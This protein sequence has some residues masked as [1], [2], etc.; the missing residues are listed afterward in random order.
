MQVPGLAPASPVALVAPVQRRPVRQFSPAQQ[1][2]PLLA[3]HEALHMP[4]P[5][6]GSSHARPALQVL[7]GQQS[8][9]AP[10]HAWHIGV[11]PAISTQRA[12]I[13]HSSSS[14]PLQQGW[15]G[16]PHAPQVPGPGVS[17]Q[18][19][20]A[21]QVAFEQQGWPMPPHGL[22]V[23]AAA[24]AGSMQRVPMSQAMSPL[25]QG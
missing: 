10:P 19:L 4:G 9:P 21:W 22:H 15:P 18:P 2:A 3:P 20:G 8:W 25:Q 16:A 23:P 14:S 24:P 5:A 11:A 6:P 1:V 17:M 13:A 7:P 12:P